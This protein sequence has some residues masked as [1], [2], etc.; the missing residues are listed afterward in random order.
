MFTSLLTG[1]SNAVSA[2][3]RG[4]ANALVLTVRWIGAATGTALLGVVVQ[5]GV[6]AG[7]LP[8]ASAY[9]DAFWIEAAVVALG[10]LA[11]VVLLREPREA[12]RH[13]TPPHQAALLAGGPRAPHCREQPRRRVRILLDRGAAPPDRQP[14][15]RPEQDRRPDPEGEEGER[16]VDPVTI[17]AKFIPKKPVTKVSGRKIVATTVSQYMVSL[18]RRSTSLAIES[19][20]ESIA[21][22]SRLS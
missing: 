5:S 22:V 15:Q 4:D 20:A 16:S 3:E 2:S 18:R 6:S 21:S 11:C 12:K 7:Q 14:G 10:A 1:L 17:H 8:G 19:D 13:A 9:S